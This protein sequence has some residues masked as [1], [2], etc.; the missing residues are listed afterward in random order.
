M[1][2]VDNLKQPKKAVGQEVATA[3]L[4]AQPDKPSKRRLNGRGQEVTPPPSWLDR[5]EPS[6]TRKPGRALV[7]P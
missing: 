5:T 2:R 7:E 4:L 6:K 1:S 3:P